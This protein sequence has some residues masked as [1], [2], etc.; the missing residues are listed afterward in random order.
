MASL[1]GLLTPDHTNHDRADTDLDYEFHHRVWQG[2][3]QRSDH[4]QHSMQRL[5]HSLLATAILQETRH[6]PSAR[7]SCNQAVSELQP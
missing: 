2:L 5:L 4:N 6:K 1:A 3:R 7:K